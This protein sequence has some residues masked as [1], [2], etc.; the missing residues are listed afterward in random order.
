MSEDGDPDA[1]A[2][3]LSASDADGDNLSWSIQSSPRFGTASVS[4]AGVVDYQP[5]ADY[6][7][8]DDF[9]VVVSDGMSTSAATAV[10]VQINSVNDPPISVTSPSFDGTLEIDVVHTINAGTWDDRDSTEDILLLFQWFIADNKVRPESTAV[11]WRNL[12]RL[13]AICF[14]S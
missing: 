7:G 2:L 1:F 13:C 6:F 8:I 5:I 14:A 11:E 12:K 10:T 4:A 9:S 3:A